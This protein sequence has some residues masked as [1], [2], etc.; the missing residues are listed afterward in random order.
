MSVEF[1]LNFPHQLHAHVT[2]LFQLLLKSGYIP[3]TWRRAHLIPLGKP[4]K[5]A[6]TPSSYRYIG[7][8]CAGLKAMEHIL[9][10]YVRGSIAPHKQQFGFTPARSSSQYLV[11]MSS[12]I[13]NALGMTRQRQA[14]RSEQL[15]AKVVALTVDFQGA[16]DYMNPNVVISLLLDAGV[17]AEV[18]RYYHRLFCSRLVKV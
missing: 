15:K 9:L 8:S 7:L 14:G 4:G 6:Y 16:F 17:P 10:D 13:A 2:H 5:R 3:P 1:L 11:T 12:Y 18:A